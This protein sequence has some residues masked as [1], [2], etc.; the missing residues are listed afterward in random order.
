MISEKKIIAM[1]DIIIDDIYEK[2]KS[3]KK[4][5]FLSSD[6]GSPRLDRIRKSF[7]NRFINVGIAEQNTINISLGLALEG[8]SV[9]VYG[10]APFI[11]MRAFEQLRVNLAIHSQIK[12]INVTI[13]GVG[14]GL[15]YDVSG[16]THHCL[17]DIAI[18]NT[19][20]N[21]SIYSPS[22][23]YSAIKLFRA[24]CTINKPKYFRLDG[25]PLPNISEKISNTDINNGFR[26]FNHGSD[27]CIISTGYM[28]QTSKQ[29]IEINKGLDIG[30]IDILRISPLNIKLIQRRLENYRYVI[31]IEEGFIGCGGLDSIINRICVQN[32]PRI[33]VRNF[34]F[35]KKFVF[36]MGTREELHKKNKL[37]Y[38]FIANEILRIHE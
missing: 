34:G 28:T 23:P 11:T 13:L 10:I 7:S 38:N 15:S 8:N 16:P 24:S 22:D 31:T 30:L 2:M 27:I 29:I 33:K 19:L 26:I 17:E 20:P 5:Y 21:F 36:E 14:A 25:K 1:R 18:I 12:D 37:D 6:F 3:D 9:I 35:E 32:I 4:I